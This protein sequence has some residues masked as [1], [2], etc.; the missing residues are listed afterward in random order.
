MLMMMLCS[1]SSRLW[2]P[3]L[4]LAGVILTIACGNT[5]QGGG[6]GQCDDLAEAV[7]FEWASVGD[8][9][10]ACDPQEQGCFGSVAEPYRISKY[11]VTNCQYAEF[12]NAVAA[13]DTNGL[14][15]TEKRARKN[16]KR[17]GSSGDFSYRVRAGR[18]NRPV[19]FVSF[20]DAARFA[21]WLHNGQP[22]GPQDD[23]TTEDGAYTL[24]STLPVNREVPRNVGA[25]IFVPSEDEWYKAAY[26]D[27]IAKVY[28]DYPV[29]SDT[30][31]TCTEPGSVPNTAICEGVMDDIAGVGFIDVGSYTGSASPNGT[32]DQGGNAL[33]WTDTIWSNARAIRGGTFAHRADD[34]AASVRYHF[35]PAREIYSFGFRV[36]SLPEPDS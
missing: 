16:I 17:T 33:E 27:P 2:L 22:T 21:N 36:A 5:G 10:N 9:G 23:T 6:S 34:L 19:G 35:T 25:Q 31:T 20:W 12:L 1:R 26:Y 7:T 29:G 28:Y 11:E 32:F 30:K 3:T 4:T 15:D 14:Y 18:E 8:P 13:T 24:T